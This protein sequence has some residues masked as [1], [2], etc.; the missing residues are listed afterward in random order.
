MRS[1]IDKQINLTD[2]LD[3]SFLKSHFLN[4]RKNNYIKT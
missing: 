3:F 2:I 4:A 1:P